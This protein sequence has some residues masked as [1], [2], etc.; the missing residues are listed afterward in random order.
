VVEKDKLDFVK[1][2][3]K[4]RDDGFGQY[5]HGINYIFKGNK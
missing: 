1:I 5:I 3:K 4:G 2:G